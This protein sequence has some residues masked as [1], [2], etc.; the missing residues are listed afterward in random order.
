ML[1]ELSSLSAQRR[2]GDV[3]SF[4]SR[5][6]ALVLDNGEEIFEMAELGIVIQ[7]VYLH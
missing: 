2:L 3:Q 7:V 4:G 5:P 1:L 6:Q